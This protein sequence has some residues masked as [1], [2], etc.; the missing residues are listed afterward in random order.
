MNQKN[1]LKIDKLDVEFSKESTFLDLI[2]RK[3]KKTV[4][5]VEDLSL[6]IQEGEIIGLVGES[7]SGKS[8]L[9]K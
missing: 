9:I 4:K 2:F 8:S 7:G 3:T 1:I 6:E 5:A